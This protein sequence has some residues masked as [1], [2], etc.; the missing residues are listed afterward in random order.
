M[1]LVL[2]IPVD[3]QETYSGPT[4]WLCGSQWRVSGPIDVGRQAN[5]KYHC[6]SYVWGQG[7]SKEGLFQSQIPI[8]DQ[9]R[10]ALEAAIEAADAAAKHSD[11]PDVKAFWIDAVCVPQTDGPKRKATLER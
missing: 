10:P 4:E 5:L 1:E 11:V 2:I 9:T 3:P 7:R 8:S 6:I